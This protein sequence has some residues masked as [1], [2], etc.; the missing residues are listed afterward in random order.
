MGQHDALVSQ[1]GRLG[2]VTQQRLREVLH[3]AEAEG[4]LQ[5]FMDQ[6]KA[7]W[8]PDMMGWER[9]EVA[10]VLVTLPASWRGTFVV[11]VQAVGA[12]ALLRLRWAPERVG[13]HALRSVVSATALIDPNHWAEWVPT[14]QRACTGVEYFDAPYVVN[15]LAG[16]P[17]AEWNAFLGTVE[18]LCPENLDSHNRT[19]ILVMLAQSKLAEERRA[20]LVEACEPLR[21][22]NAFALRT[23]IEDFLGAA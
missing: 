14:V 17:P 15:A 9:V 21:A 4:G 19:Q 13:A 7:L 20:R 11:A 22:G 2:F 10:A 18:K 23:T 5:A 6:V 1:F 12:Q 16:L 3:K 8:S